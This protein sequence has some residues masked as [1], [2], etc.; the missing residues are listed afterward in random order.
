MQ[1]ARRQLKRLSGVVVAT[2]NKLI[3]QRKRGESMRKWVGRNLDNSRLAAI[4][5]LY[6]VLLGVIV[7]GM[8]SLRNWNAWDTSLDSMT[9]RYI[10]AFFGTVFLFDYLLRLYAADNRKAHVL[11]PLAIMDF[12]AILPQF[13][14]LLVPD[15]FSRDHYLWVT[16]IKT[17]RPFR[18]LCCFRLLVF[19][20]TARQRETFV[21][22]SAVIC[23]I[24]CFG[25][26]QQAIEACPASTARLCFVL[27]NKLSPDADQSDTA[28][29]F[30]TISLRHFNKHVPIFVQVLKSDNIGHLH[31]SGANNVLCVDQ[32]KLAILA[33]SCLMPGTAALIC[34]I[35]FTFRPAVG[36]RCAHV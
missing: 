32:L 27:A 20:T 2:R 6:Q 5:D 21:L 24:I 9:T 31:L 26:M 25:S 28:C 13:I 18:C 14:E 23:I 1:Q 30:I 3:K 22:F 19:A 36:L 34:S 17:F 7:T 10:Q 12:L 35:L 33:K 29:N 4:L 11:A 8:Y 15:S 16:A